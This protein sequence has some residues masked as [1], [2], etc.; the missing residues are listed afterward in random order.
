[1]PSVKSAAKL[2]FSLSVLAA[3]FYLIDAND[4]GAAMVSAD[5]W[6]VLAA[7][8]LALGSQVFSAARLR[9]LAL[10]QDISLTFVK[11]LLIGLSAVFYGLV[12]PGGTVGAFAVR[13]IQLSREARVES[14]A[15]TLIMDRVVATIFLVAIGIVAICVDQAEPLL[16][17]AMA[18]VT[19]VA[20]GAIMSGRSLILRTWNWLGENTSRY[21]PDKAHEYTGRITGA[22]ANYSS[23]DGRQI[24]IV[25]LSTLLAHLFG[26]LVYYTVA[27]SLGLDFSLLSA[28]WVRSGMILATMIPVSVAGLGLRE[29]AAIVL[30]APLGIGEAQAVGFAI[31]VFL[32]T[33]VIVG[34]IG[35]AAE[36]FRSAHGRF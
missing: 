13:F 1:M 14:V 8:S 10:L 34:L 29:V 4:V 22:L 23:A 33:P 25:T 20:V 17:V 6:L 35:G 18:T 30:L 28:C 2:A 11:V 3:I 32:V 24:A 19:L 36:F 16:A 31:L 15:V 5:P 7:I 27:S 26:C 9:Q 12:V 21:L